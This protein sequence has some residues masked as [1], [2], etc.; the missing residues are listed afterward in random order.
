MSQ[1]EAS[2][3]DDPSEGPLK[4]LEWWIL[5]EG[6]RITITAGAVVAV[7]VSVLVLI[8]LD[9][10]AVGANSY[11]SLVFSGVIAGLLTLITV[12][13]TIN[14]LILSRVFGT[15]RELSDDLQGSRQYRDSIEDLAD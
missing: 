1:N 6:D 5:F 2:I 10:I 14:Q 8:W 12:T 7:F 11:M 13:L 4:R 3:K 15:P 9:A